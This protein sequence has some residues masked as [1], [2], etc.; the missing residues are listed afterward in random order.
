MDDIIKSI[1]AFL[2]DRATSPLIGAFIIAWSTWN[3]KMILILLSNEVVHSKFLLISVLY[4][5]TEI[6][7]LGLMIPIP[8]AILHG[9]LIPSLL[10]AFYIYIYPL[11]AEPVYRYSLRKQLQ[12]KSIKQAQEKNTLLTVEESNKMHLEFLNLENKFEEETIQYRKQ[13]K[14]LQSLLNAQSKSNG[15]NYQETKSDPE[16]NSESNPESNSESNSESNPEV[17][18]ENLAKILKVFINKDQKTRLKIDVM[19]EMLSTKHDII[20]VRI[21]KLVKDGYL[22]E[23]LSSSYPASYSIALK[24]KEY[25]IENF[26]EEYID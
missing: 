12:L 22:D 24:G 21:P 6:E 25:L 9:L 7:V 5:V 15:Q 23:H 17:L 14:A 26:P 18:N 3:Y 19:A 11:L 4:K 1:K 10:T 16:S 13:I 20:A 8:Y 2:Y